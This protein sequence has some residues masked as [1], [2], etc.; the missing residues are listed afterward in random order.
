MKESRA[1]KSAELLG[2]SR[3]LGFYDKDVKN[4]DHMAKYFLS[5]KGIGQTTARYLSAL[6]GDYSEMAVDSL[7]VSYMARTYFNGSKPGEKQ[8]R[9]I[10]EPFGRWKYLVYWMEF[11]IAEGWTPDEE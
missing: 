10:Y 7:V 2:L 3:A 1:I 6:Y 5:F 11:I 4:P 9:D 8:I